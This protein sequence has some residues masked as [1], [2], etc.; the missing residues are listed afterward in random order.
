[1]KPLNILVVAGPTREPIDLVRF[2]TNHST[3]TMGYSIAATARKLGHM[4]TL[5]TGPTSLKTPGGIGIIQVITAKDMFNAVKA[6]FK[7]SDCVIM[8]AAVSDFRPNGYRTAKIKRSSRL[9]VLKL[10]K[11]PDILSWIGKRKGNRLLIGFCMETSNLLANARKKMQ[12]KN[13]DIIVANKIDAQQS[14]FGQGV[15]TVFIIGPEDQQ[16]ELRKKSKQGIARILLEKIE[17]LWY[18]R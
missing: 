13:A 7:K 12:Q 6:N 15:T 5:V 3:G 10:K 14:V 8:A 9:L 17:H 11:N 16:Q 2:I 1:M 4:V 18:K